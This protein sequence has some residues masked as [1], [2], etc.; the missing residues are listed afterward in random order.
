MKLR[1]HG[2]HQALLLRHGPVAFLDLVPDPD[3]KLI[4]QDGG[5]DVN[6]ELLG[7]LRQVNIFRQVI[8]DLWLIGDE[9]Q[10]VFYRQAFVLG[11]IKGLHLVPLDVLL[12]PADD[13]LQ[14]VD[15]HILCRKDMLVD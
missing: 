13:G 12:L 5:A 10:H 2:N 11:H 8:L 14:V 1:I 6:N 9:L 7:D 4:T 3:V 15:G